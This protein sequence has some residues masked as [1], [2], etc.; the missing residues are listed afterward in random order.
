MTE[1]HAGT[2]THFMGRYTWGDVHGEIYMEICTLKHV[3]REMYIKRYQL[4][5]HE[6]IN[7]GKCTW[8]D[9]NGNMEIER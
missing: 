2:I 7:I 6:E 1:Y 4:C 9:G 3:H 8:K 5:V